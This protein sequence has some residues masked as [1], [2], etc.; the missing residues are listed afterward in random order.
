LRAR[1]T[2]MHGLP[3][4]IGRVKNAP[5][6]DIARCEIR[7]CAHAVLKCTDN[8]IGRVKNAPDYP[9]PLFKKSQPAAR[10]SNFF[11]LLGRHE[12]LS[13]FLNFLISGFESSGRRD[14]S[15]SSQIK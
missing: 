3:N 7:V 2:E 8:K 9:P 5:D 6:Y 4:K 15:K 12:S 11:N 13:G 10:V 1:R 14:L